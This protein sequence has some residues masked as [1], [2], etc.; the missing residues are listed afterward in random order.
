MA[1]TDLTIDYLANRP[2][3]VDKLAR[4]S[5]AEWQHIYQQRGQTF[6]DALKNYRERTNTD[7]LPLALVAVHGEQLVGTVSL[8]FRDL[9]TRPDLDPWLGA[10][11]VIPEWR[12][13][14]VASLLMRRAVEE[15]KRLKLGKLFLWSSSAEELYLKLGWQAVDRTEYSG[16]RIVIMQMD[17]G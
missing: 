12:R 9:D 16:K 14:G 3:F 10:L 1:A 13:R 15:A 4:L 8:K 17:A 5:W 6:E 2:E 11:F 7:W